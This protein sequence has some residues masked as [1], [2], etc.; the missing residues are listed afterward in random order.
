MFEC[1]AYVHVPYDEF[2]KLDSKKRVCVFI[3][4]GQ[5]EFGYR[6]WDPIHRKIVRSRDVEFVEDQT[7]EDSRAKP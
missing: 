6:L 7:I 2:L 4:Y 1:L 5:D 3:G